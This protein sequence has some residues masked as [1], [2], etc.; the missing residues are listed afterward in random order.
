MRVGII[1]VGHL[2]R[3][4]LEQWI[5]IVGKEN[6]GIFDTDTER[7][8]LLQKEFEVTILTESTLWTFAEIIDIVTPTQYHFEWAQKAIN[9]GKHFFVEKPICKTLE[10]AEALITLAKA[11][12]IKAQVGHV[13]RFN[14]A[15]RAIQNSIENPRFFEI[16]RLAPFNPRG[17]EVSVVLD[18]MIHDLDIVLWLVKSAIKKIDAVGVNI[19][20]PTADIANVRLEFDNGCVVNL[21]S[22]RI[23]MK[24][25]RKMRIFQQS[26]YSSIDFLERSSEQYLIQDANEETSGLSFTNF[27]G[28]KKA[29]NFNSYS[30]D[31]QNAIYSELK[32]FYDA[33][34][35]NS[36]ILV[37]LDSGRNALKLALE[38]ERNM[39]F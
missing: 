10:E 38:I 13:E 24:K 8:H 1:G 11:K 26:G 35:N 6:I 23:S 12:G 17:T 21:T 19:I 15:F 25:M 2:G 39:T 37:D 31:S 22:S 14:P 16:H 36:S 5:A 29:V 7:V 30:G 28:E 18:L 33:I 27:L 4:H 9:N 20:S 32:S 3:F 34:Q